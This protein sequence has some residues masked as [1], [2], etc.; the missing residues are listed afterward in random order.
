VAN[1]ATRCG[2]KNVAEALGNM[3]DVNKDDLF[4]GLHSAFGV[5]RSMS[6]MVTSPPGE[7]K[8]MQSGRSSG[9]YIRDHSMGRLKECQNREPS[10]ILTQ[11]KRRTVMD[12]FFS[13]ALPSLSV[14]SSHDQITR[15]W[16]SA[17]TPEDC[18]T[19]AYI[20]RNL[21]PFSVT[22]RETEGPANVVDGPRA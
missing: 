12:D 7:S 11:Y 5:S 2:G 22:I 4:F 20:L 17:L 1:G 10:T 6:I 13:L 21:V 16:S 19:A 8:R 9:A 18:S 15:P 14:A 3:N